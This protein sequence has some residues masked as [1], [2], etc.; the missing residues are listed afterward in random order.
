MH[1]MFIMI[2]CSVLFLDK[3]N[4]RMPTAEVAVAYKVSNSTC[5]TVANRF[6]EHTVKQNVPEN[7]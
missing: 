7:L 1:T 4:K 3:Y 2:Q 6:L 5:N